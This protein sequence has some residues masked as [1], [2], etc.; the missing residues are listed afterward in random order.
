[1]LRFLVNIGKVPLRRASVEAESNNQRSTDFPCIDRA[2]HASPPVRAHLLGIQTVL[3]MPTLL[4]FSTAVT[5]DGRRSGWWLGRMVAAKECLHL[6]NDLRCV[7]VPGTRNAPQ[8]FSGQTSICLYRQ[9]NTVPHRIRCHHHLEN[10]QDAVRSARQ[11]ACN[12]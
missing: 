2:C 6:Y 11:E 12:A 4:I 9:N 8:H 3:V 5:A 1:M 10:I 7:V